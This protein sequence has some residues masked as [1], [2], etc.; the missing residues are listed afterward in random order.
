M[1]GGFCGITAGECRSGTRRGVSGPP[2]LRDGCGFAAEFV[3]FHKTRSLPQVVRANPIVRGV[4]CG[5][6]VRWLGWSRL[7]DLARP[8]LAGPP[9][10]CQ[11]YFLAETE[12]PL[13]RR[14]RG[15]RRYSRIAD[16][17]SR[18]AVNFSSAR[19][20]KRFPSSPRSKAFFWVSPLAR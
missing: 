3:N 1:D 20:T 8:D 2:C 7:T 5:K 10:R 18:K 9:G 6:R 16:S 11:Y 17:N 12:K 14:L 13:N 19:T 4:P 15:F